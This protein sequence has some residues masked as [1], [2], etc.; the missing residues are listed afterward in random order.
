V[1]GLTAAGG[2]GGV[3]QGTELASASTDG[4]L[5]LWD[6]HQNQPLR[7][8][9]GHTNEKNFVGLSVTHDFVACGSE[10]NEVFVYHKQVGAARPTQRSVGVPVPV[11]EAAAAGLAPGGQGVPELPSR[12]VLLR[13]F[14]PSTPPSAQVSCYAHPNTNCTTLMSQPQLHRTVSANITYGKMVTWFVTSPPTDNC[15]QPKEALLTV[16]QP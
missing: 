12:L 7:T 1:Y 2:S 4:T 8:L 11:L 13:T 3:A 9:R 16:S 14:R 5:Q 10:T 6:V 15:P